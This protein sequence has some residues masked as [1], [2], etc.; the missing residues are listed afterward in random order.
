[1]KICEE[2]GS[3]IDKVVSHAE[4]FQLPAP[5]F[6][7]TPNHTVAVL[8]GPRKF[9]EMDK[10]DRIR[11]CY[12]HACLLYVSGQRMTNATLRGR[13]GIKDTNY[14]V[15]SRIIHDAIEAKLIRSHGGE[16][17]SRKDNS[18]VPFWA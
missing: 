14:P 15:A 9:A 18:Y 12:Q 17:K 5:D 1:M 2:R 3:G 10:A 4:M 16:S 7:A 11:G 6:R 13:L 8:F